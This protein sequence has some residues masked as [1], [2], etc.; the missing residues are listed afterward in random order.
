M[1]LRSLT[2][3]KRV[4]DLFRFTSSTDFSGFFQ[5]IQMLQGK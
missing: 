4:Y 3:F 5:Q 2:E 1:N